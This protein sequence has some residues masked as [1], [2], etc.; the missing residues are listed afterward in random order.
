[1]IINLK[2]H[3]KAIP[4]GIIIRNVRQVVTKAL[5]M[6]ACLERRENK[7]GRDL[8][9]G[10]VAEKQ[11]REN[12]FHSTKTFENLETAANGT[13]IFRK[14]LNFRN[15]NH[16]PENSRNSGSKVEWKENL[17]KKFFENLGTP[18]EVVLFVGNFGKC[19]S[20]RHCKLP[21]IQTGRFG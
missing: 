16:S 4:S 21:K 6:T 11:E 12:A 5:K 7:A 13:E 18:R 3:D 2:S 15:A 8:W 17:R 20:I 10:T 9:K 1:M 19:C 14:L